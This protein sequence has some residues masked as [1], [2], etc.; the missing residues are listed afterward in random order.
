MN[1]DERPAPSHRGTD[2][3]LTPAN[4]PLRKRR[5]WWT[6]LTFAVLLAGAATYLGA[7]AKSLLQQEPA[8]AKPARGRGGVPAGGAPIVTATA[9]KGD[10]GVYINAL[11]TV[12]PVYTVTLVSRVQ[13]SVVRVA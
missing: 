9:R 2:A 7:N 1:T 3:G 13:G 4:P 5:R 11:G 6:W 8:A 12:T 10:I